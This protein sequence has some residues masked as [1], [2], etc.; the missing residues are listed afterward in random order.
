LLSGWH[1]P[2]LGIESVAVYSEPDAGAP[3]ITTADRA[4]KI[5]PAR[6]TESYLNADAII[7]AAEDTNADALHPGYGLFSENASFA[8]RIREHSSLTWVGPDPDVIE[9][10]GEKTRAREGVADVDVPP[11]PGTDEVSDV[12]EAR[13]LAAE[14]GYPVAVKASPGAVVRAS[15]S[16]NRRKNFLKRSN[17]PVSR[18]RTTSAMTLS[19]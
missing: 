15:T 18:D 12:D 5:G 13:E 9:L 14:I 7:G 2:E 11:I 6:L 3:H 8:R 19:I 16:L 17:S 1:R 4:V 10:M